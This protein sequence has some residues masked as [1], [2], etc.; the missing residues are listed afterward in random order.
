M[1]NTKQPD[2]TH[3]T[4]DNLDLNSEIPSLDDLDLDEFEE[5][6]QASSGHSASLDNVSLLKNI[7]VDIT[8]EISRKTLIL[9]DL[10]ELQSGS[11]IMLEK[12]EGEPVEIKVNG[13]LFGTGEVISE[14]GQYGVR[15][16]SVAKKI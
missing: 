4:L 7:P 16:L 12:H 3:N 13:T 2:Q 8:V 6:N 11:V 10:L 1:A 14:H 9:N 15:L 5:N